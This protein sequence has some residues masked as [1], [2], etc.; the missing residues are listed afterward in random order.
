MAGHGKGAVFKALL[1]NGFL[2]VIKFI[3]F[4]LSGSGAIFSEAVHS[5]A[6]TANQALLFIGVRKS[7]RGA[8]T[9]YNY[10][11]GAE[12]YIYALMSAIGIFI[13]GCGVTIYHGIA[14]IIHPHGVKVTWLSYGV[15]VVAIVIE[16]W[17][18]TSAIR[19]VNAERGDKRFFDFVR[20][21]TDP[22]LVAVLFEDAV[23]V[24]G[25]FIAL[26]GLLLADLTG[27]FVFDA[28]TSIL[29][30]ILLGGIAIWLGMRN[31]ELILGPSIPPQLQKQV[32]E[33]L[34][35]QP[36][37]D[38][39]RLLRT[40]VAAA[41][42][43]TMAA[44]VDYNGSYLGQLHTDW[45]KERL[46]TVNTEEQRAEFAKEFGDR[47]LDALGKEVDRLEAALRARFPR[48]KSIS[49]ESD[50]SPETDP[51]AAPAK[52]PKVLTF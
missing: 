16:G 21:S 49:L 22:T 37:V 41:D 50:W 33:F 32:V 2:T 25:A 38:R 48:I 39:V 17:V 27:L 29:V 13:L 1:G 12:R 19:E 7:Q 43:F 28:I 14:G 26:G 10:G 18:L 45:V 47:L 51:L 6:D 24:L 3:A 30:G 34:T 9:K 35:A 40:R 52:Q 5:A 42:R 23:A 11:Y 36:S 4:A 15:L 8:D 46:A 20:E 44:E 31:R